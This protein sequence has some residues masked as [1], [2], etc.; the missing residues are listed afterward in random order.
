MSTARLLCRRI[1]Q[2][3][4]P[5]F[6]K[7]V[8]LNEQIV[9]PEAKLHFPHALEYIYAHTN[10]VIA[11]SD[12]DPSGIKAILERIRRLSSVRLVASFLPRLFWFARVSLPQTAH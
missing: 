2:I 10:H 7:T 6:F 12:L 9:S 3:A 8:V 1:N 4:I 11:R 5:I